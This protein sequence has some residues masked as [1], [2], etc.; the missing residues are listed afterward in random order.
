MLIRSP[1]LSPTSR[2]PAD[3]E[4]I[5]ALAER[6]SGRSYVVD[7]APD[8]ENGS[9]GFSQNDQILSSVLC[10]CGPPQPQVWCCSPRRSWRNWICTAA[11]PTAHTTQRPMAQT[12]HEG[13]LDDATG[14]LALPANATETQ[15]HGR[16]CGPWMAGVTRRMRGHWSVSRPLITF[17][18]MAA[19]A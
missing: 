9:P 2:A 19:D 4:T 13:R 1:T 5:T 6:L 16:L 10:G 11:S 14:G 17:A 12:A 18:P 7:F 15:E 3:D 8:G